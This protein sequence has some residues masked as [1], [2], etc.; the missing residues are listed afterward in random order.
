MDEGEQGDP[1]E[2]RRIGL[3]KQSRLP[4]PKYRPRQHPVVGGV[5]DAADIGFILADVGPIG[6][7][8][9]VGGG[10]AWVLKKGQR[11]AR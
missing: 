7:A 6:L 3:A 11:S 2:R 4:N 1:D 9:G 10:I 8:I 5:V